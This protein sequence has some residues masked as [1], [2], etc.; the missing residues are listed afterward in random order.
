MERSAHPDLKDDVVSIR[1]DLTHALAGRTFRNTLSKC[2]SAW[3][4]RSKSERGKTQKL[5]LVTASLRKESKPCRPHNTSIRS[6]EA[7]TARRREPRTPN[8]PP[9][10]G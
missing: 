4:Q 9:K 6:G 2:I 1:S 10:T 5:G 8:A 3:G 7:A